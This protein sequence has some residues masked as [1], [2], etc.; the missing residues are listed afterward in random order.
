M[1]KCLLDNFFRASLNFLFSPGVDDGLEHLETTSK[2]Q[3][4]E[5]IF[6]EK[7]NSNNIMI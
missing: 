7:K 5:G 1:L 4:F 3:L 2:H 6:G